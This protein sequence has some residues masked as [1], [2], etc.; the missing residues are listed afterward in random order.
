M[1]VAALLAKQPALSDKIISMSRPFTD[2]TEITFSPIYAWMLI[3]FG[4]FFFLLGL[5]VLT[6]WAKG[7]SLALGI[8]IAL[9]AAGGIA[10]GVIWLKHLPVVLRLTA[11][12]LQVSGVT[13]V[14]WSE[15]ER[16]DVQKLEID[17]TP[18]HYVCIRLTN[19]R[20]V[21]GS[22]NRLFQA[23]RNALLGDYDIVLDEQKYSR[24]ADWLAAECRKRLGQ[25]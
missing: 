9:V 24:P 2:D 3:G 15:I 6:P 12:E 25:G 7:G 8:L 18:V 17:G 16:V 23:G 19:R 14:R 5:F 11:D 10:G 21:E 4:S 13:P 1:N 20:P 22:L